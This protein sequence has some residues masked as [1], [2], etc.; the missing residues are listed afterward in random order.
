MSSAC[1]LRRQLHRP[2]ARSTV[3]SVGGELCR[4]RLCSFL[5]APPPSLSARTVASPPRATA[6]PP[7]SLSAPQIWPRQSLLGCLRPLPRA[8]VV[9]FR[10]ARRGRPSPRGRRGR[11]VAC[12]RP[13]L[14][15]R[16]PWPQLPPAPCN[17]SRAAPSHAAGRGRS[18]LPPSNLPCQDL[19]EAREAVTGR[20]QKDLGLNKVADGAADLIMDGESGDKFAASED[21]TTTTPVP[22]R[23][24]STSCLL[25]PMKFAAEKT[26]KLLLLS[27]FLELYRYANLKACISRLPENGDRS[28]PFPWPARLMEPPKRLQGVEM[29][30][31]SSKKELFKAE[32]KFWDDIVEGYI[33]VFKWRKLK[34]RDV[35][36]MRTGFGGYFSL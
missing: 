33:R 25:N 23:S 26:R 2:R 8:A 19:P 20:A 15:R 12:R 36:D 9:S 32:I 13:E 17:P 10:A 18:S 6:A 24:S 16:P 3:T 14:P 7:P 21:E 29:D 11:P 28:T 4:P 35:L 27:M 30:A 5:S 34:L 22:E 1:E 31:H